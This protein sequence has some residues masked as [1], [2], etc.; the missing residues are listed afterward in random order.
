VG[1]LTTVSRAEASS[2]GEMPTDAHGF[3]NHLNAKPTKIAK[4]DGGG[5]RNPRQ[6]RLTGILAP[7]RN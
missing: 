2:E 3:L 7:A 4:M 6:Q 1:N 5:L